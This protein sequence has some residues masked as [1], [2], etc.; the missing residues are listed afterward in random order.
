MPTS[1]HPGLWICRVPILWLLAFAVPACGD[2]ELIHRG[3]ATGSDLSF[4]KTDLGIGD[5]AGSELAPSLDVAVDP[6][7]VGE[8]AQPEDLTEGTDAQD[9]DQQAPIDVPQ[10]PTDV[11]Q[12]DVPVT[13]FVLLSHTPADGATGIAS[14]IV[15]TMT[16]NATV[17]PEAISQNTIFVSTHGDKPVLG[18]FVVSDKVVTFTSNAAVQAAS[19]VQV[20][21]TNL[22]QAK[23]G[24]SLQQEVVFHFYTAP[25]AG[26]EPYQKLAARYAPMIRQG[27]SADSASAD[28]LRSI[29]L[30][31][32]WNLANNA[33]NAKKEATAQ[34]GWSVIETQSHFFVTYVFYWA[35]RAAADTKLAFDNDS[36]GSIVAIAKYP[37][38]HPVALTTYFKQ[39]SDEQMWTW[40]TAE[41]GL[42]PA[43]SKT[44]TFLRAIVAQDDLFPK[45]SDP[46]DTYGCEG[47]A[48]CV[49][50]RYPAF[51]T[52]TSHQSCLWTDNGEPTLY[53]CDASPPVKAVLKWIEYVPGA[54]AQAASGSAGAPGPQF[55]YGLQSL[56]EIWWPHRDEA[57]ASALFVDTQFTYAP[58]GD[59][60]G[61][62]L[63]PVGSKF[64]SASATAGDYGRP[65]WAW[66]WKPGTNVSYIDLPRGTVFY[67]PSW[68][69]FVRVHGPDP[70]P[71]V[72][73]AAQKT[74]YS[75]EHCLHPFFY[76]DARD[77]APCKG[78]LP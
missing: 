6:A 47:I 16:F 69:L 23:K 18:K 36:S 17:K 7:D 20:R 64:I 41:S 8:D 45:S 38:E 24:A 27:I 74:G 48:G 21:L 30:D 78:S 68:N 35:H 71:P 19:R 12:S 39:K 57:G 32:D 34:V 56:H 60:P 25:L 29:D 9:Q 28:F 37:T 58:P 3:D 44:P 1:T 43:G 50:R 66:T 10:P 46:K 65:P 62:G 31:G 76:I 55:T 40:I 75:V 14:P 2:P 51:L 15:V 49:P 61:A 73:N 33:K 67:D 13:E 4:A 59:R 72:Y 26:L 53:E 42:L 63:L 54:T 77:T 70:A 5:G 22:V 11:P 52:A